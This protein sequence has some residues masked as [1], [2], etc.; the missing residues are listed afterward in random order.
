MCVYVCIQISDTDQYG[1]HLKSLCCFCVGGEGGGVKCTLL[2]LFNWFFN[3]PVNHGGCMS[4]GKETG[5]LTGGW[6]EGSGSI[7]PHP[8]TSIQ[9]LR[10]YR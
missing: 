3:S 4:Q 6:G 1:T 9:L 7:T 10:P 8:T 5:S 2:L